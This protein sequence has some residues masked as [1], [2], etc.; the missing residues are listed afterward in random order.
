M[1]LGRLSPVWQG[2]MSERKMV[3]L[4]RASASDTSVEE[5]REV[6]RVGVGRA[7]YKRFQN[8]FISIR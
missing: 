5:G 8:M 1:K 4:Q 3:D 2:Q 6:G 7:P